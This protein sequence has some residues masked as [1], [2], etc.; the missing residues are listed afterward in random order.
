MSESKTPESARQYKI[1]N[2]EAIRSRQKEYNQKVQSDAELREKKNRLNRESN[3]RN[4]TKRKQY[5]RQRDKQKVLARC[6]VRNRIYRGTIARQ[7]CEKC[8]A[9]KAHAHHD[10][11][12][13]PLEIRWLCPLHHKEYHNANG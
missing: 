12:S 4:Y 2:A 13:K 8:G 7:P 10:D 1:K 5:D 9:E 11:Y 6:L 3:A